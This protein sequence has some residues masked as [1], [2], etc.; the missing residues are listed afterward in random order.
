MDQRSLVPLL[1]G[2]Y[3]I[4]S[5][6]SQYIS[7]VLDERSSLYNRTDVVGAFPIL[8]MHT[9]R[10]RGDKEEKA[11]VLAWFQSCFAP[12]TGQC[13]DHRRIRDRH[14]RQTLVRPRR[15]KS[16]DVRTSSPAATILPSIS[17]HPLLG[18][19]QAVLLS[20][21]MRRTSAPPLAN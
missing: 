3:P 18:Q 11:C 9:R 13:E 7:L 14:R 16:T 10:R 15:T 6:R 19:L 20:F 17:I 12:Q 4:L 5:D 8:G 1:S 21:R 2:P